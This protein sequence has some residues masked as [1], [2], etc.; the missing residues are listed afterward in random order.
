M[1]VAHPRFRLPGRHFDITITIKTDPVRV[2]KLEGVTKITVDGPRLPRQRHKSKGANHSQSSTS[3]AESKASYSYALGSP[4]SFFP[5]DLGFLGPPQGGGGNAEPAMLTGHGCVPLTRYAMHPVT[6]GGP[7][8]ARMTPDARHGALPYPLV[9]GSGMF[10]M[11]APQ[12]PAM[13]VQSPGQQW[14]I[15]NGKTLRWLLLS[16]LRCAFFSSSAQMSS[17][18]LGGGVEFI[19]ES[20][21]P[22]RGVAGQLCTAT[23]QYVAQETTGSKFCHVV[24]LLSIAS[25]SF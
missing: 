18:P 9:T 22:A 8:R 5:A 17:S 2:G 20:L 21:E 19:F 4:G 6:V 12:P 16:F 24:N 23:L 10:D 14:P 7:M 1:P 11:P 15:L 3:S 13:S 25:A